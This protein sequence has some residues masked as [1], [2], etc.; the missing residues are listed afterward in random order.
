VAWTADSKN[1]LFA[2]N[3]NGH[4]DIFRQGGPEDQAEVITSGLEH[5]FYQAP[6]TPDGSSL[7]N[8]GPAHDSS[9]GAYIIWKISLRGGSPQKL[10]E[11]RITG[12]ECTKVRCVYGE[13][14]ADGAAF[15]LRELNQTTPARSGTELI[16]IDLK[17]IG[18]P[19][20]WTISPTG[21]TVAIAK[22]FSQRI[23]LIDLA[24]G[25]SKILEVKSSPLLRNLRWSASGKGL[26]ASHPTKGGAALLYIDLQGNA[27]TLWTMRG[28]N[29]LLRA[30][31]APDGKRLAIQASSSE[32]N[33]WMIQHF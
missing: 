15:T 29:I 33:V 2:S 5:I 10:T 20:S 31:P 24:A 27:R 21:T 17:E 12:V 16:R 18:T 13:E 8:L 26:F 1:V 28:Q 23:S 22:Q 25:S 19:Y 14:T 9:D 4:W 3:R 11:G 7:L 6:V 30:I 32:D